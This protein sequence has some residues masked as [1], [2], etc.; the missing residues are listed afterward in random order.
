[1]CIVLGDRVESYAFA[2]GAFFNKVPVCH[3]FGGDV[4]NV[5]YFDTNIRHAITKISSLHLVSNKASLNNVL[6]MGEESWRCELIGNISLD[7]YQN[8]NYAKKDELIEQ[9]G[10]KDELTIVLTYHPSQYVS[11]SINFKNF[12]SIFDDCKSL[13]VQTVITYPNNDE[14]HKEITDFLET[15]PNRSGSIFIEKNLGIKNYLGILKEFNCIMIGNSSSGLYE[16][17][18]TGTPSVN[19]G[20]RQVDR[21]RSIN[22]IDLELEKL[23]Q[24]KSVLEEIVSNYNEIKVKNLTDYDFFG[25][26]ESVKTSLDKIRKFLQ[27]DIEERF[28]KKLFT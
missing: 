9:Y 10:L 20:D 28:F 16:T 24:L 7:N 15:Q 2:N 21:P 25:K 4:S 19:I 1:M 22:V 17:A 3:I 6:R 11:E 5:P 14:G 26:G 23:N 13:G 12:K 8:G 18:Y 27:I